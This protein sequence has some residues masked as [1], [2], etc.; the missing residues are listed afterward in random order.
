MFCLDKILSDPAKLQSNR[1]KVCQAILS[2]FFVCLV[3]QNPLAPSILHYSKVR[4]GLQC[5]KHGMD[6]ELISLAFRTKISIFSGLKKQ[7]ALGRTC[8]YWQM[9]RNR[10]EVHLTVTAPEFFQARSETKNQVQGLFPPNLL[11]LL[12]IDASAA[13]A[14]KKKQYETLKQ[15]KEKTIWLT[16]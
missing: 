2:H 12:P 1:D 8:H 13:A 6:R 11:L 7:L 16:F 4:Q 9:N 3:S 5:N 15:S 14:E 10:E